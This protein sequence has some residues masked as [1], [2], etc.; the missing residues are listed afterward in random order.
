MKL[1]LGGGDLRIDGFINVDLCEGADVK[2]DL[3]LPL[4]YQDE[5]VDEI[6]AVHVIESFYKW[7]FVDVLSD[8]YRVL[9]DGGKMT[10]EFTDLSETIKM[11]QQ[12]DIHGRWGLHG[13]QDVAIDPI[14][15]HHY[16]YEKSE[17]EQ[18]LK[19]VGF[20]DIQF[21]QQ[22]IMH[23]PIRDWRVVCYR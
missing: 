10:I 13:N 1:N 5:S 14:V 16:V 22:G 3:R 19:D 7:E 8:W 23:M 18:L 15:L 9:K 17:L 12:G 4:P 6:V 2:H 21:T 20:K 11:Y